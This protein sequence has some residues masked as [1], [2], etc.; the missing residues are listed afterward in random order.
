MPISRSKLGQ[1]AIVVLCGV[2][3]WI[4]CWHFCLPPSRRRPQI[5]RLGLFQFSPTPYQLC[6]YQSDSPDVELETRLC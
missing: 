1:F 2:V 4:A 6:Q 5:T 3:V